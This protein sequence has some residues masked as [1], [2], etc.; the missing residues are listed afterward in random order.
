MSITLSTDGVERLLTYS[1]NLRWA[2]SHGE[3][4]APFEGRFVA[5]VSGKVLASAGTSAELERKFGRRK[6]VYIGYVAKFG[7]K[8]VL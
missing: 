2:K 4:L 5:V 8:W 7:S 3:E 1:R 6:G